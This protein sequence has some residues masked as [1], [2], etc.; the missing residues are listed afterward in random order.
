MT[1][2]ERGSW[3]SGPTEFSVVDGSQSTT[4]YREVFQP[5]NQGSS[6]LD[7][8]SLAMMAFLNPAASNAGLPILDRLLEPRHPTSSGVFR[9][10][11]VDDRLDRL[12]QRRAKDPSTTSPRR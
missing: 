1:S 8:A 6:S 2:P 11:I 7:G 5:T 10:E 4:E 3:T 12:G 9:V